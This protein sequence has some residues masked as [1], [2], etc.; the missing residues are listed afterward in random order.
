ME[1]IYNYL[2][3]VLFVV[4]GLT[5]Y[6]DIR[7]IENGGY[8]LQAYDS[9]YVD[10]SEIV[11]DGHPNA[12]VNGILI[13]QEFDQN[14]NLIFEWDAYNH[15]DIAQY[16]NLNL[17]SPD[18]TWMHGN[19]V[20]IDNDNNLIL[21]NR[22][23]SEILKIN[24]ITGEVIWILGGPLNEF[25]IIDDP[26]NGFRKQHDAT[27]LENGNLLLFDNGNQHSPP[28]TRIV[29]YQINEENKTA[30]LIWEFINPN[31]LVALNMGSV[32]RL[33]NQNT[34]I[35][36]GNTPGHGARIMEVNLDYIIVL[37]TIHRSY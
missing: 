8:I 23:S 37:E 32:Q 3:F 20:K 15:L 17:A 9:L 34:L 36:W 33:P 2:A 21:S 10:M 7:V 1:T 29:E 25:E 13:I 16:T 12:L 11:D 6:H 5:D 26:L 19:S 24:R 28:T 14:N 18:F 30:T 35:S 27:I 22:R 31:E 4:A